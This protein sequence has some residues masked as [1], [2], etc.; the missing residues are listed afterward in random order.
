[1][2]ENLESLKALLSGELV[3]WADREPLM[4][5]EEE[6]LYSIFLNDGSGDY[7]YHFTVNVQNDF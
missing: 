3:D 4:Y 7:Y 6:N 2:L 5:Q 1:M